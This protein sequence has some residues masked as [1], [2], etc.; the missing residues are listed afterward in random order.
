MPMNRPSRISA[1]RSL[2]FELPQHL[3]QL[4]AR[5]GID[6]CGRLVEE[7]YRRFVDQ[8]AAQG[9]FLFH[10]AGKG[11]GLA[12]FE[13]LDLA[14]Y[15]LDEV[16]VFPDRRAEHRGKKSEVLFD[17]HVLVE[18]EASR[19]IAHAVADR[20][21]VAHDVESVHAGRTAVGADDPEDLTVPGLEA[22][23]VQRLHGAF[24]VAFDNVVYFDC[25]HYFP[26]F[27]SAYMPILSRPSFGTAI[28][29]A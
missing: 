27:T 13:R 1:I 25:S 4:L 3:P 12:V 10:P 9:Q 18:G 22:D 14:V 29:T 28:F 20:F 24:P 7:Q 19:H 11:S 6:P 26:N 8:C 21:V 2:L 15:V 17:C 23:A 5:D 16:V